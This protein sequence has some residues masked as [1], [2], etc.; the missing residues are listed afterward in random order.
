VVVAIKPKTWRRVVTW[1]IDVSLTQNDQDQVSYHNS[2]V[3][4]QTRAAPFSG[5]LSFNPHVIYGR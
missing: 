5:H 4:Q 3:F 2:G 1:D